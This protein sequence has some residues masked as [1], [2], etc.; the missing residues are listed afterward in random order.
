MATGGRI[1]HHLKRRLPD[2]RTTVLLTGFQAAG[3]RGRALQEGA[4]ELRMHGQEVRVRAHVETVHG[5]SAHADRDELFRWLDGFQQKPGH[6]FAVHGEANGSDEFAAAVEE[7][8]GWEAS[9]PR[10][11]AEH[12]IG[13]RS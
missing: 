2:K 11:G 6:T 12:P 1:L 10:D 8:L 3:T 9:V 13:E 5:L 4:K 7:R